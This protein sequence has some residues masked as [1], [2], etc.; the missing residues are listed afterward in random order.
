M[1]V[2]ASNSVLGAVRNGLPDE[3]NLTKKRQ[4]NSGKSKP[5]LQARGAATKKPAVGLRRRL[6]DLRR[7]QY[8]ADLP[9]GS[10]EKFRRSQSAA[11]W[12]GDRRCILS[13]LFWSS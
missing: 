1:I 2:P 4:I 6:Y 7:Y 9:D 13:P 8:P 10:S 11:G 3:S 12:Q 5:N